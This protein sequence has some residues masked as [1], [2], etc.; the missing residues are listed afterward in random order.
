[1]KTLHQL[2]A[3]LLFF[4]SITLNA[5]ENKTMEINDKGTG[6]EVKMGDS[7][8]NFSNEELASHFIDKGVEYAA[9]G[10]YQSAIGEFNVAFLYQTDNYLIYYYRGLAY[11]YLEDS[12][13]AELNFTDAISLNENCYLCYNQRGIIYS[14]SDRFLLAEKDFS[15]AM[16]ID[17]EN[18]QAYLNAGINYLIKG[19]NEKACEYLNRAKTLGNES[20]IKIINDYCD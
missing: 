17:P 3:A 12:K 20:A 18:N 16:E 9:N 13:E 7:V 10:D 5:Q 4:A 19:D 11:Y 6:I 2:L 14:K 8:I 15:K 1:M